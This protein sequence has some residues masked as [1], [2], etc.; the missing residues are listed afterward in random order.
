MILHT[1]QTK[2]FLQRALHRC[3]KS[4]F[5]FISKPENHI[6]KLQVV[7]FMQRSLHTV[8]SSSS[9]SPAKHSCFVLQSVNALLCKVAMLCT[10]LR[11]RAIVS[12][13][14]LFG[15]EALAAHS[16]FFNNTTPC[17]LWETI[18]TRCGEQSPFLWGKE[19]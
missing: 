8:F 14:L 6:V 7:A 19:N 5:N 15:N 4:T 12:L 10:G 18:P 9:L 2:Y 3:N 11:G 13:L 16:L 1:E 17:Y